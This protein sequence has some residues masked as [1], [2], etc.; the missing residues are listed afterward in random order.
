MILADPLLLLVMLLVLLDVQPWLGKDMCEDRD[1]Q[2]RMD[3]DWG[4]R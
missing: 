1:N 3:V 2:Q 4:L